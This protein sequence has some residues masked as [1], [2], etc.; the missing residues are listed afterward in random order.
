[1]VLTNNFITALKK[2]LLLDNYINENNTKLKKIKEE[3]NNIELS[4]IKY[5]EINNLENTNFE[6]DFN[7]IHYSKNNIN[8]SLSLKL[9]T[10]V[11]DETIA[12]INIKNRI[13]NNINLKKHKNS[14]ESISLKRKLVKKQ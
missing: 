10:E 5:I 7:N 1:M 9:L 4:L 2:W 6:I 8:S 14:K 12:D 11:L 13:L 3:K